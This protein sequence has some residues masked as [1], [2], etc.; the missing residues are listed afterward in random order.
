MLNIEFTN[1]MKQDVKLMKKRG[2]NIDKLIETLDMLTAQVGMPGKYHDH[3]LAGK[4]SDFRE[5]H[6]EPDWILIYQVFEEILILIASA[7]GS[8]SDLFKL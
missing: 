2:K 8:H 3:Q 7:T 1:R 5:C 4:W 6:I